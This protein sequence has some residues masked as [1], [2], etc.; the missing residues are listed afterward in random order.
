MTLT[1]FPLAIGMLLQPILQPILSQMCAKK[2]EILPGSKRLLN[3]QSHEILRIIRLTPRWLRHQ[4][5]FTDNFDQ[6]ALRF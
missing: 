1:P 3:G 4:G 6:M 2:R 5:A